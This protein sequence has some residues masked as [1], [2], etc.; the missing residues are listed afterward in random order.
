MKDLLLRLVGHMEWADAI[1]A[2][3]IQQCPATVPD[4]ERLFAH[5]AAA[6]HL[7]YSRIHA[8]TPEFAVWPALSVAEARHVARREAS[9]FR[10][11]IAEVDVDALT[12]EVRYTNSAGRTFTNTIADI[13]THVALHGERHRGQIARVI[14]AAGGEPPYTDFIQYARRDQ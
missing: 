14:R 6:E 12:F 10:A 4:A 8:L 5:I 13:V 9:H 1:A 2:D 3:A 7:W 11:M